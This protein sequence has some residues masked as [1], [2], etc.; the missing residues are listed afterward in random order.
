MP[1]LK[2]DLLS[3]AGAAAEFLGVSARTVYHMAES[4][5]L[6]VI[7]K[8]KRLYFLKSD[9]TASFKST[10]RKRFDVKIPANSVKDGGEVEISVEPIDVVDIKNL[11]RV[12]LHTLGWCSRD[13]TRVW[14]RIRNFRKL[15]FLPHLATGTG[16]ASHYSADDCKYHVLAVILNVSGVSPV[17]VIEAIEDNRGSI[18]KSFDSDKEITIALHTFPSGIAPVTVTIPPIILPDMVDAQSTSSNKA[19]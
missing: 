9:L 15:G 2:D 19:I 1:T 8:G 10:D 13:Y 17:V 14:S 11:V 4:G 5:G 18:Q 6:P 3:G 12:I 7:R 16:K